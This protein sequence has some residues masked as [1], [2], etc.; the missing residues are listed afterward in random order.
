[1]IAA[2]R[3]R[4]PRTRD[5][6]LA[7]KVPEATARRSLKQLA[8]MGHLI[9]IFPD[10]FFLRETLAEMATIAVEIADGDGLLT[11]AE[12]G[13][14]SSPMFVADRLAAPLPITVDRVPPYSFL[15]L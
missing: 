3:F 14:P 11:V 9:E 1:M 10:N 7:L 4:P 13:G 2:E 15:I 5:I 12:V 6:A 8:R